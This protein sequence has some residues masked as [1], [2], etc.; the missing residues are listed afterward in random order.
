MEDAMPNIIATEI[1]LI[2]MNSSCTA[3]TFSQVPAFSSVVG[4]IPPYSKAWR[5]GGQP[6]MGGS[7]LVLGGIWVLPRM[8]RLEG[9]PQTQGVEWMGLPL[10]ALQQRM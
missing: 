5:E 6:G 10:A 2:N 1:S 7:L 4:K 9:E 8:V 3:L